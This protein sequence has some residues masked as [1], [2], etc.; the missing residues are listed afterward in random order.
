MNEIPLNLYS[1]IG[2]VAIILMLLSFFVK[3]NVQCIIYSFISMVLS[4]ILA[5]TILDG[6]VVLIQVIGQNHIYIPVTNTAISY[7]WDFI[8]L[9][10]AACMVMYIVTEINYRLDNIEGADDE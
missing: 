10:M 9:L 4:F 6:S 7:F 5:I 3:D 8:G 1:G 2:V